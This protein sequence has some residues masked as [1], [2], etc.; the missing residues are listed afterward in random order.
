[1]IGAISTNAIRT[2]EHVAAPAAAGQD[3]GAAFR[4]ILGDA[5]KSVDAMQSDASAA[6]E[7]FLNGEGEDLHRVALEQQRAAA[8]F[9]LFLQ[10]R[11]KVVQAYQ[12]VM[13]M[14]V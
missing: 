6:I 10:V 9:D 4:N 7:R 12:E 1:M 3:G 8:G 13:R 11:N 2:P 5:V 14:Q